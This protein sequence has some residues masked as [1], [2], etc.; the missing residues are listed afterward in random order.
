[1]ECSFYQR[2]VLACINLQNMI[3][4][5]AA[6]F[7]RQ[8]KIGMT[9]QVDDGRHICYGAKLHCQHVVFS[10]AESNRNLHI[11]R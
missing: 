6:A 1:M 7:S 8:I 10:P 5:R 4:N 11:S 2:E 9:G 3:I